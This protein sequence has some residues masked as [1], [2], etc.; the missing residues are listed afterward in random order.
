M[1]NTIKKINVGGTEYDLDAAYLGGLSAQQWEDLIDAHMSV[2]GPYTNDGNPLNPTIGQQV[3]E[4]YDDAGRAFDPETNQGAIYLFNNTNATTNCEWI[5]TDT[6][7]GWKWTFIGTSSTDMQDYVKKGTYTTSTPSTNSTGE[8]GAATIPISV[9]VGIS[10][11]KSD[12]NTGSTAPTFYGNTENV[13]AVA[14]IPYLP[15]TVIS[16]VGENTGSS[17]GTYTPT[18][19]LPTVTVV[20]TITFTPNGNDTFSAGTTP[21]FTAVSSGGH[22]YMYS[23][24]VSNGVLSW[25]EHSFS[26]GTTPSFTQG[27]KASMTVTYDDVYGG[28]NGG[29]ALPTYVSAST[30]SLAHTHSIT[31]STTN[32]IGSFG[33]DSE[34]SEFDAQV[35][36]SFTPSGTISSHSHSIGYTTASA[37]TTGTGVATLPNH[38][39]SLSNHTHNIT[40]S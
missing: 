24:T 29:A 9:A 16:S 2:K 19:P 36:F 22:G 7:T 18:V 27:S 15:A 5:A 8:G 10:Y 21:S 3:D 32:V 40:F 34:Y 26:A 33:Y 20:K 11:D 1:P 6:E 14:T 28:K 30:L 39:H 17:L 23:P 38:T 13:E 31:R 12:A 25:T 35:A 4:L 37:S